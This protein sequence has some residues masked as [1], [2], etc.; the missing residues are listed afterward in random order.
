ML[1]PA[2]PFPDRGVTSVREARPAGRRFYYL[3][4]T[5]VGFSS[6]ARRGSVR[7]MDQPVRQ[8]LIV[9][10]DA[11]ASARLADLVAQVRRSRAD[12][13]KVLYPVCFGLVAH[14]LSPEA[15]SRAF[16]AFR[17]LDEL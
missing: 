15:C 6:V 10:D 2:G 16:R 14:Q 3:E 17:G 5:P 4:A 13:G 12:L 11:E 7:R 9:R 8:R 1:T